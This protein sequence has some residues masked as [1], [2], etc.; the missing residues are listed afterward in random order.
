MSGENT[1]TYGTIVPL[2]FDKGEEHISQRAEN[3]AQHGRDHMSNFTQ[4]QAAARR[5]TLLL[6][7]WI[8]GGKVVV[9]RSTLARQGLPQGDNGYAR[10]GV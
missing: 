7:W 2:W 4:V 1:A 6:L 8:D 3:V 5:K 10:M 9:V